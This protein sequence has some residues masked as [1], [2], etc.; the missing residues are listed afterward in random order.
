MKER[1]MKSFKSK[2]SIVVKVMALLCSIL[3][4]GSLFVQVL[5]R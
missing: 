3:F 5:V 2:Y 4:L 1:K